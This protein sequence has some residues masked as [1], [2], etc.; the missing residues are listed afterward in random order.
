LNRDKFAQFFL[1]R[2]KFGLEEDR[3]SK[4]VLFSH[5]AR[6]API[7]CEHKDLAQNIYW[8]VPSL[9]GRLK[10]TSDNQEID[11]IFET[12]ANHF[13]FFIGLRSDSGYDH[14]LPIKDDVEEAA[15][16]LFKEFLKKGL[17]FKINDKHLGT[18]LSLGSGVLNKCFEEFE[19]IFK[20]SCDQLDPYNV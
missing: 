18:I 8:I 17:T 20:G 9:L 6:L 3:I 7:I 5:L 14:L 19:D 11:Q 16:R 10:D 12:L 15:F 13:E 4:P 1:D 2:I